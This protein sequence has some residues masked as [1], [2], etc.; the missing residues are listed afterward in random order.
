[1][2]VRHNGYLTHRLTDLPIGSYHLVDKMIPKL[3][4]GTTGL[5]SECQASEAAYSHQTR[6]HSSR[7]AGLFFYSLV[8]QSGE[9]APWD[10][11][12]VVSQ[13]GRDAIEIHPDLSRKEVR[14]TGVSGFRNGANK[15]GNLWA[16]FFVCGF[17]YH[18]MYD[19]STF[20]GDQQAR[21]GNG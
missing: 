20:I 15:M 2:R 16:R 4:K 8:R 13:P 7:S 21:N 17:W 10:E 6:E 11:H 9:M 3:C 14:S 18:H 12:H 19:R 5:A 1:M